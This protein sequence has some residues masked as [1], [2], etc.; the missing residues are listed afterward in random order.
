MSRSLVSTEGYHY[1]DYLIP[2]KF[3]SN[4]YDMKLTLKLFIA[5]I[6]FFAISCNSS[7]E[8]TVN[9]ENINPVVDQQITEN[10]D[11]ELLLKNR[12][13]ICHGVGDT[14]DELIAPPMRGVKMH[15]ISEF[16]EKE[17]FIAAVIKWSSNP[18]VENSL[19]PGALEEFEVM[20]DLNYD[21]ADIALIA[22][23][24]YDN[25]MPKPAWA[26]KGNNHGNGKGDCKDKG[27]GKGNGSEKGENN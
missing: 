23:Y 24:V 3:V 2:F 14:H 10:A 21:T 13:L 7:T 20:A 27:Q 8:S 5:L 25:E 1:C 15:Y 11:V 19:M 4:I 18:T 16:P 17:D 6:P 12:C 22:A 9:D 26:G